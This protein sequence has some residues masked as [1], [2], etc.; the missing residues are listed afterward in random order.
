MKSE[1]CYV[2]SKFSSTCFAVISLKS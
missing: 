2:F 1:F